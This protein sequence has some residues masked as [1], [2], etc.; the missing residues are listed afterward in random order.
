MRDPGP[1]S[2][3]CPTS[4]LSLSRRIS[5]PRPSLRSVHE[6]RRVEDEDKSRTVFA[7]KVVDLAGEAPGRRSNKTQHPTAGAES[8]TPAT[9]FGDAG[10]WRAAELSRRS[11]RVA[12]EINALK[13]LQRVADEGVRALFPVIHDVFI[14][15]RPSG[16]KDD[17]SVADAG[18]G[19]TS[20]M[21]TVMTRCPGGR[22]LMALLAVAPRNM[23]PESQARFYAA[24]VALALD[25]VHS[26][27][28][29]AGNA[30]CAFP[31]PTHSFITA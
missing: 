7:A 1:T 2:K 9:E 3:V 12:A 29:M 20:R 16:C 6:C 27:G 31:K 30:A 25:A 11:S 4:A 14:L 21:C 22:D 5:S 13:H 8:S 19:V 17:D 10:E 24:E 23:L 28:R 18:V 15:Q 26:V